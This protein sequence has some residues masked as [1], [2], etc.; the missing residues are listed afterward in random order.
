MTGPLKLK[1]PPSR[2]GA[3]AAVLG[4]VLVAAFF[5]SVAIGAVSLSLDAVLRAIAGRFS[6]SA[7]DPE[8]V[9]AETVVWDLRLARVLTAVIIGASL[10]TCGAAMQG[11]F[12]NPLA[13]PGIIGVSSGASLGAIVVVVLQI[14]TFGLWTLPIGAF[15]S[16]TATTFVIMYKQPKDAARSKN[17]F[18]FFKWALEEGQKQA[19]EL[20]YVPL[21]DALVKQI[22]TYWSSEFKS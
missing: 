15:L 22:E 18:K 2:T 4:A 20:D 1:R 3:I 13:D 8:A 17:G 19:T 7:A 14:S 9:L 12:G 21:P 5:A 6:A 11:I 16:G 10:A